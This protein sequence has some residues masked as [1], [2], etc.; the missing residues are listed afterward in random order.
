MFKHSHYRENVNKDRYND[1]EKEL[2]KLKT[3]HNKRGLSKSYVYK[4]IKK[5]PEC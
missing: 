2:Q 5:R 3:K 4:L 1:I